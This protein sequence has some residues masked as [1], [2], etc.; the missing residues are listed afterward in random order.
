MACVIWFKHP[1]A[2][3]YLLTHGEVYTLRGRRKNCP[4]GRVTVRAGRYVSIMGSIEYV[5]VIDLNDPAQV[6]RL[7]NYVSKSGF[8][9]VEEWVEAYKKLNGNRNP[10]HL[11]HVT[12]RQVLEQSLSR[13]GTTQ[14]YI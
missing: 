11:Y 5:G 9:S 14:R 12:L 7:N 13:W 6:S 1:K 10:T 8:S 2:L 4:D 3:A